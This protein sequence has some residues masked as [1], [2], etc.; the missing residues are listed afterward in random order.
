MDT[1]IWLYTDFRVTFNRHT[2]IRIIRFGTFAVIPDHKSLG[3][4]AAEKVFDIMD[5]NWQVERSAIDPP[6]SVYKVMN[7]KQVK[8]WYGMRED[9][10]KNVD[11]MVK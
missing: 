3:M 2:N 10:L 4:Q 1:T 5:N 11:K 7:F 6:T 8:A 9:Q